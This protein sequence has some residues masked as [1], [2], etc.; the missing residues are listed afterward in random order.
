[1]IAILKYNLDKPEDKVD[2]HLA[3][4]ASKL[5]RLLD[6]VEQEIF[7]PARKHGYTDTKLQ[8]LL[9]TTEQGVEL[10]GKLEKLY[11][12]FKRELDIHDIYS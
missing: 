1:M 12:E 5:A 11:Y 6:F 10:I 3:M 4:Q 8:A 9:D 7:R 2:H